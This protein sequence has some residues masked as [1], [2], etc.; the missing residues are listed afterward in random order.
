MVWVSTVV[1]QAAAISE[2]NARVQIKVQQQDR[3]VEDEGDVR[4]SN[5]DN[6][7]RLWVRKVI[8]TA[9]HPLILQSVRVGVNAKRSVGVEVRVRVKASSR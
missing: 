8:L 2:E 3:L 5:S 4:N 7:N 1:M 9:D 6:N